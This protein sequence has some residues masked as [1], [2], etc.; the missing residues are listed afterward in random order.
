[1]TDK[2]LARFPAKQRKTTMPKT[3]MGNY[4]DSTK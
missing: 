1:M 2:K 4:F 3:K